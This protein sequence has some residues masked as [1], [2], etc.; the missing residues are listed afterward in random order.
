MNTSILIISHFDIGTALLN[1]VK[2]TYG[3][4]TLP[5]PIFIFEVKHDVDLEKTIPEI[6]TFVSD[7]QKK[8]ESILILTDLFG[9]TPCN[10]A[11]ALAQTEKIRI[12]SGLNLPM[13]IRVMNYP[14]LNLEQLVK[15]ALQGGQAGIIDCDYQKEKGGTA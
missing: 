10:I 3:K 1:A 2:T 14:H 5:L 12:V 13:L 9:A 4:E 7:L 11:L 8:S 6:K 15:V